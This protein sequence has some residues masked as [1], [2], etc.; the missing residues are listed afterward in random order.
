M[1][2]RDHFLFSVVFT[3]ELQMT[4]TRRSPGPALLVLSLL[5]LTILSVS[6]TVTARGRH[7]AA[8]S[9]RARAERK[10][11]VRVARVDSRHGKLSRAEKRLAAKESRRDGR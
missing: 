3:K 6:N 1:F 8:K 4:L 11:G 10:R 5:I 7:P 2:D 9:N